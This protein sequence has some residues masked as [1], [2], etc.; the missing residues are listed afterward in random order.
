MV[1]LI[2][3]EK[4]KYMKAERIKAL[5]WREWR[6]TRKTYMTNI[7][8]FFIIVGFFWLIRLSMSVG[9]LAPVFKDSPLLN[10]F[11]SMIYYSAASLGA[12]IAFVPV[13]DITCMQADINANWLRYSFAL[14]ITPEIR[15][16]ELYICKLIKIAA[17]FVLS[18][19]NGLITAKIT[20]TPFTGDMLWF[21]AACA[22]VCVLYDMLLQ[23]LCTK[24]RT[25]KGLSQAQSKLLGT[26]AGIVMI[27]S[28]YKIVWT[29][30]ASDPP[31]LD[32]LIESL[33]S[34]FISHESIIIPASLILLTGCL[35]AGW[36]MTVRNY[37]MF[38][39]AAEQ[40]GAEKAARFT[41][42]RK[43]EGE[44]S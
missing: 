19:L 3:K 43:K 15:A 9:N 33:R 22:A 26:L 28:F 5:L 44:P 6:I 18:V 27:Y 4:V 31:P 17:A 10:E 12:V 2:Q 39:D 7:L 20:G 35:L 11:N 21:F 37:R 13:S 16:T 36:Y 42:K 8:V 14:P 29:D 38:G 1:I 25:I 32:E 23:I 41:L 30:S 34:A 40:N 24:A